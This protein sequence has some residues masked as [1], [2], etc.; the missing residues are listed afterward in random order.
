[1]LPVPTSTPSAS[2][3]F[4][5]TLTPGLRVVK[6]ASE[7]SCPIVQPRFTCT[8]VPIEMSVV[9]WQPAQITLPGATVTRRPSQLVV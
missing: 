4:P 1:M 5:D 9:I 7:L 8:C 3:T 2:S 6:S